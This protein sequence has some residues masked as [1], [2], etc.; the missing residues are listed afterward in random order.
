MS[1][2]AKLL[3]DRSTSLDIDRP[4]NMA[5]IVLMAVLA[6]ASVVLN[7]VMVGGIIDS[8][9]LTP[10][11][12]GLIVASEMVGYGVGTFGITLIIRQW[13]RRALLLG[14]FL[15]LSAFWFLS[16]T[17]R[18]FEALAFMRL[19]AGLGA[20]TALG[21]LKAVM[22]GSK[23]PDRF[24]ALYS[25]VQV[26][27]GAAA[28][29]AMSKLVAASGIGSLYL[30]MGFVAA[31]GLLL[32]P[33]APPYFTGAAPTRPKAAGSALSRIVWLA[34]VAAV[35]SVAAYFLGQGAV[36]PFLG[37][38]GTAFGLTSSEAGGYVGMTLAA[39]AAGAAVAAIIG[40]R[41]GRPLAITIGVVMSIASMILLSRPLDASSF[42]VAA[43]L[44]GFSWFFTFPYV[45]GMLA[46]IDGTGRWLVSGVVVQSLAIAAA[47]AIAGR[48]APNEV[49]GPV[50]WF[51]VACHALCLL[52]VFVAYSGRS[53]SAPAATTA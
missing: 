26:G 41:L 3:G 13:N 46:A 2:L 6:S 5:A 12:A 30:I 1:A 16:A 39:G 44:F 14:G 17:A 29:L 20:G 51:G 11:Q 19:A 4:G 50:A 24:F 27:L 10:E 28:S 42:A 9:G 32:I 18:S 22:A 21:A 23:Q 25:V 15:V 43:C 8:L 53:R 47:P 35:A 48:L 37:R 31:I 34:P 33:L 38:F 45:L 7:P 49:Y 36:W 52:L 40:A